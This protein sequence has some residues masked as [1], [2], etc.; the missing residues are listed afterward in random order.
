MVSPYFTTG[1]VSPASAPAPGSARTA[2]YAPPV[3]PPVQSGGNA[4]VLPPGLVTTRLDVPHELNASAGMARQIA[5]DLDNANGKAGPGAHSLT[6]Y[7]STASTRIRGF[8][9]GGA[10]TGC[11]E[12]WMQQCKAL[13]DTLGTAAGNLDRTQQSYSANEAATAADLRAGR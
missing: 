9:F 10:L 3:Q 7:A 5:T 4:P 13:H 6:E 1:P 11:T 2:P 8:S 12:R